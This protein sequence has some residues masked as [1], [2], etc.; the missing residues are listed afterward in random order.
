MITKKNSN[1]SYQYPFIFL[2]I[3]VTFLLATVCLASKITTVGKLLVPG[4]IFVFGLTFSICEI[5]G[6]VYGYAYPRLFIWI[7]AICEIIFALS[8][9]IVSHL[10]SPAFFLNPEAYK[11]VFDPS[12]RFVIS[13]IIGLVLGEF[14]NIYLLAKWKIKLHGRFFILRSLFSS[15]LGQ[16]VLSFIVVSLNYFGT[17]TIENLI[18]LMISG[19]I[20]KMCALL[21]LTFPSWILV[22]FLKH[23][24]KVDYYDINTNFNPFIFSL[25]H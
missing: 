16:G 24:E 15:A 9:T 13:S 4:G 1:P 14:V 20:W 3:Y 19:Y 8:V 11:I 18:W 22:K 21:A 10:P 6:E 5:V 2:G 17:M 7:G 12:I 25:N 23:T